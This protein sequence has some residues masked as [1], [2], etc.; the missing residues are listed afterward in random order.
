GD[1]G[2]E[3]ASFVNRTRPQFEREG[4]IASMGFGEGAEQRNRA[5][6][7]FRARA[8]AEAPLARDVVER[9]GGAE[10]GEEV[11]GEDGE[12]HGA[13]H[14]RSHTRS[15]SRKLGMTSAPL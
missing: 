12:G 6:E 2:G 10:F 14:S 1:K 4:V 7:L 11:I 5:A 13:N 9:A 3:Q 8:D 15:R